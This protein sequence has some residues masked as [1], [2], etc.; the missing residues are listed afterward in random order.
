MSEIS[1]DNANVSRIKGISGLWLIPLI[2][3]VIGAWMIYNS[4]VNQGPL[5]TITF[6]SADGLEVEK[7]KIKARNVEVGKVVDIA[8]NENLDG[9]TV[10]ARMNNEIRDMLVDGSSFWVVQPTIGFSG[11]S[12][13]GTL[14]SGQYIEFL[15]GEGNSRA[16]HFEG[17]MHHR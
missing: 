1:V 17:L 2:T 12:G 9:V 5:V 16:N 7:T 6:T 11:V 4:W 8:L 13:L 15:R 10:S 14:F 3:A